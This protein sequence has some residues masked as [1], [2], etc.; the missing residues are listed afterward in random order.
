MQWKTTDAIRVRPRPGPA[1]YANHT[2]GGT[3]GSPIFTKR[4]SSASQC[5]GWW[6]VMAVHGYGIYGATYPNNSLNHGVR[7]TKEVSGMRSSPG[8]ASAGEAAQPGLVAP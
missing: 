8:R 5:A 6:C 2:Y 7:M 3:S 4:G 1:H